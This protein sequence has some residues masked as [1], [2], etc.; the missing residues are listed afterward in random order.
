MFTRIAAL[1]LLVALCAPA[2][3]QFP[4]EDPYLFGGVNI[5]GVELGDADGDGL[6]DIFVVNQ[7]SKSLRLLLGH[8]D[9][10]FDGNLLP[11]TVGV[12][13]FLVVD[14]DADGLDDVVVRAADPQEVLVFRAVGGGAFGEPS[15]VV[16]EGLCS[17]LD[18][19]DVDG[20]GHLDLVLGE[21]GSI[22]AALALGAGDGSF[23][24]LVYAALTWKHEF[25]RTGDVN[26]DGHVDL[27]SWPASSNGNTL[28][29]AFGLGGASFEPPVAV[30]TGTVDELAV[31][32]LDGD[33]ADDLALLWG[34]HKLL[35]GQVGGLPTAAVSFSSGYGQS[36]SLRIADANDDGRP[37]LVIGGGLAV[38]ANL[39]QA[40][41]SFTL[42]TSL[43]RQSG[44]AGASDIA[45][46]DLD[47][48]GRV[49]IVGAFIAGELLSVLRGQD[50][51]GFRPSFGNQGFGF[52]TDVVAADFDGD[53]WLDLL[54]ATSD[55]AQSLRAGRPGASFDQP[56]A[57]DVGIDAMTLDAHDATGDGILDVLAIDL[58]SPTEPAYV[59]IT[60]GLGDLGFAAP[61]VTLVAAADAQGRFVD[62]SGDRLTDAIVVG[63]TGGGQFRLSRML[64]AGASFVLETTF[65]FLAGATEVAAIATGDLNEDGAMD[66]VIACS[67]PNIVRIVFGLPGVGFAPRVTLPGVTDLFAI[68]LADL[69]QDGHLDLIGSQT[70]G[71]ALLVLPGQ[72]DGSFGPA[73]SYPADGPDILHVADVDGDGWLDVLVTSG[74]ASSS[75]EAALFAGSAGGSL[76]FLGSRAMPAHVTGIELADLDRD[77]RP[78]YVAACNSFSNQSQF[79]TLLN[80]EG[81]WNTVPYSLAGS[82]GYSK[83][84]GE[85]SLQ[86]GSPLAFHIASGPPGAPVFFIAS[87]FSLEA[88]FKGGLLVPLPTLMYALGPLDANGALHLSTTWP[89]GIAPGS[90][91]YTQAWFVD[92]G[93]PVGF[94]S[95]NGLAGTAP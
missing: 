18:A 91:A 62:F 1:V 61:A 77:G 50:D 48:D 33:G 17:S 42:T 7:F 32:D 9:G 89:T 5:Q 46:A 59:S 82:A 28:E 52:L 41:G 30:Y 49:D 37:D 23:L 14:V 29:V 19:A 85:G 76:R 70:E 66:T 26:G 72:G 86:P 63:R 27:L 55:D 13:D 58:G 45:I 92:A 69:D 67:A 31:G 88:P 93:G 40:D 80:T 56:L 34:P 22:R 24:P 6:Q 47:R 60:A 11:V 64:N 36:T 25:V 78:D 20:D 73:A 35:H 21:Q 84:S 51:G 39:Q 83:L 38:K 2:R 3:A 53:G 94:A 95:T 15:V 79:L 68:E 10:S 8:G 57:V 12:E 81:P 4:F 87:L 16:T 74:A 43:L 65:V 44:S 90:T 54:G 71:D 75:R